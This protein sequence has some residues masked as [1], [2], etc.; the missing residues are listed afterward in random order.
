MSMIVSQSVLIL[1]V[2][3]TGGFVSVMLRMLYLQARNRS[4]PRTDNAVI[5]LG[6][7]AAVLYIMAI[8]LAIAV[9]K[10]G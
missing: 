8:V 3:V 10:A 4:H 2:I 6:L 7:T 9:S 5:V 1:A